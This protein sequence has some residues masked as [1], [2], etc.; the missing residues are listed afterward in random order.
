MKVILLLHSS[1]IEFVVAFNNFLEIKPAL[2]FCDNLKNEYINNFIKKYKLTV[3]N[4]KENINNYDCAITFTYRVYKILKEINYKGKIISYAH[5]ISLKSYFPN[6]LA[7]KMHSFLC[8]FTDFQKQFFLEN[9]CG[10]VKIFPYL[11]FTDIKEVPILKNLDIKKDSM[12]Y[13]PTLNNDLSNS[14]LNKLDNVIFEL[15][16][17]LNVYILLHPLTEKE[18]MKYYLKNDNIFVINRC[19]YSNKY[20]NLKNIINIVDVYSSIDILQYFKYIICD[21]STIF[22]EGLLLNKICFRTDI[23][24]INNLTYDNIINNNITTSICKYSQNNMSN[25][26]NNKPIKLENLIKNLTCDNKRNNIKKKLDDKKK[27]DNKKKKNNKKYQKLNNNFSISKK[28]KK[29]KI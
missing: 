28:I 19:F 17:Y 23:A 7:K 6:K 25:I 13:A 1:S 14:S 2:Y 22:Y 15:S 20:L 9:N 27:N 21:Q 5:G 10:K 8:A 24:N 4:N 3:I 16:K 26:Y 11:K 12:I 29:I 18:I